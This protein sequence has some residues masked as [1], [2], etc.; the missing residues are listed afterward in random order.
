MEK[1]E[2]EVDG[3]GDEEWPQAR[4]VG[5]CVVWSEHTL[6]S[7][8]LLYTLKSGE[9]TCPSTDEALALL[10]RLEMKDKIKVLKNK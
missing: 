2:R 4:T 9:S 8:L 6:T 5:G 10:P 1:V 3:H 7:G